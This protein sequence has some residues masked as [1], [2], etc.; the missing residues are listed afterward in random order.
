LKHPQLRPHEDADREL[1][2]AADCYDRESPGLAAVFLDEIEIG[3]A[4]ILMHP[5]GSRQV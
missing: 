5:E 1:N 4:R 2:D 3:Y